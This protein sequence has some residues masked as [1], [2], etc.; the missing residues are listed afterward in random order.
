[1]NP[2]LDQQIPRTTT[3]PMMNNDVNTSDAKEYNIRAISNTL[4]FLG[5]F[6]LTFELARI[7]AKDPEHFHY[8]I[9][10]F[11]FF[12]PYDLLSE[13][14]LNRLGITELHR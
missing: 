11:L 3:K 4:K 6:C 10:P 7:A 9:K 12:H 8:N 5:I 1:M 13:E 14:E 2:N